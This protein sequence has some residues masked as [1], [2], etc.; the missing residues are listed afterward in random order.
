M[1]PYSTKLRQAKTLT[2]EAWLATQY[3]DESNFDKLIV[4]FIIAL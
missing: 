2:N 3:F 1:I 4:G